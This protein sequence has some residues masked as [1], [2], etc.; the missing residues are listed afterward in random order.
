[1]FVLYLLVISASALAYV[2]STLYDVED[3]ENIFEDFINKYNKEYASEQE[4]QDRFNIFKDN[5]KRIN[6]LRLSEKGK[7]AS[8]DI[9]HLSDW[10]EEDFQSILGLRPGPTSVVPERVDMTKAVPESF[11]WRQ[12]QVFNPAKD[13]GKCGSCWAFSAIGGVEAAYAIKHKQLVGLS[14]QQ[15]VDCDGYNAGCHGGFMNVAL[16]YLKEVGGSMLE[17]DYPYKAVEDNCTFDL[18]KVKVKILG[19]RA[20]DLSDTEATKQI[21]VQNGPISIGVG[22][23]PNWAHYTGGIFDCPDRSMNHGVVLVGYGTE[24]GVGYWIIRNSWSAKWGEQGYMR[25]KQSGTSVNSVCSMTRIP[26]SVEAAHAIKHNYC[27]DTNNGCFGGY[28]DKALI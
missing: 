27:D 7:L 19:Q 18:S 25:I 2:P 17:S 24:N 10:S 4:K 11:D 3:A 21:L 26:G 13:Q 12:Q 6:E 23:D 1:M 15:L 5:L 28:M 9:N 20:F 22:A 16:D 8:F 14:E